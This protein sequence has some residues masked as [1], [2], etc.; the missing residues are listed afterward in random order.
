MRIAALCMWAIAGRVVLIAQ[1]AFEVASVKPCDV[2]LVQRARPTS[3][4]K[5]SHTPV[6]PRDARAFDRG[7]HPLKSPTTLTSL[8]LGAHTA[9]WMPRCPSTSARCAPIFS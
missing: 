1:P 5:P 2:I 3:G 8:A 7:V 6:A 9:K 4:I